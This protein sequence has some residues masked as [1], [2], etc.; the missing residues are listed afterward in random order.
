MNSERPITKTLPNALKW[1]WPE[2]SQTIF[3]QRACLLNHQIE[4]LASDS[5][6]VLIHFSK[7][8]KLLDDHSWRHFFYSP[9]LWQILIA[10]KFKGNHYQQLAHYLDNELSVYLVRERIKTYLAP[11]DVGDLSGFKW[12]SL[13]RYGIHPSDR[14]KVVKSKLLP[15]GILLD[16]YSDNA[17]GPL[18]D[19]PGGDSGFSAKEFGQSYQKTLKAIALIRRIS[20]VCLN[21]VAA[22]TKSIIFRCDNSKEGAFFCSAS[23]DFCNG[24]IVIINPQLENVSYLDIA[25]AIIHESTHAM[26]DCAEFFELCVPSKREKSS[27]VSPW[28]GRNLDPNTYIQACYTWFALYNFWRKASINREHSAIEKFMRRSLA[29]FENNLHIKNAKKSKVQ[30]DPKLYDA[31]EKISVCIKSSLA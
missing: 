28:S 27:V 23:T 16:A 24:Q 20:P 7:L 2:Y 15:H 19:I 29:G 12:D 8:L 5:E 13:G 17:R 1:N 22:A 6:I 30:F 11:E 26:F 4:Y 25:D 21:L 3:S 14:S 10:T 9:K 18:R 31:L